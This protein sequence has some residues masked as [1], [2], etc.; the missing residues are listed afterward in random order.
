MKIAE[1]LKAALHKEM[2]LNGHLLESFS[3]ILMKRIKSQGAKYG[4]TH[5]QRSC[6]YGKKINNDSNDGTQVQILFLRYLKI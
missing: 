4:A 3:C 6:F 2:T 5:E 1:A